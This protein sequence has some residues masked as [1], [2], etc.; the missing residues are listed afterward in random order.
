ME[1]EQIF[2]LQLHSGKELFISGK[3]GAT[4]RVVPFYC[5]FAGKW[6]RS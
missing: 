4:M 1:R 2:F 3:D 6:H 5:I